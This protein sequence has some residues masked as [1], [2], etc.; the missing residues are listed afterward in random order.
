[1]ENL[2]KVG[3]NLDAAKNVYQDAYKQLSTG[4]DN[5]ILQTEKLKSLGL[6]NKK[7]LPQSLIEK[8]ISDKQ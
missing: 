5:L 8:A 3:K 6:K 7:E 1:V 2:E 4:S